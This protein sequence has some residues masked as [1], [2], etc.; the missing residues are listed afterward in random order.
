[1]FV[2][3]VTKQFSFTN[4]NNNEDDD[5][6]NSSDVITG[7]SLT[8]GQIYFEYF[9]G[10]LKLRIQILKK[11]MYMI[12]KFGFFR[13]GRGG[14]KGVKMKRGLPERERERK[15]QKENEKKLRTCCRVIITI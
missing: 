14:E 5:D 3:K 2:T 6:D 13:G 1:M 8:E 9:R 4:N 15:K 12:S 11:N 10:E 7:R